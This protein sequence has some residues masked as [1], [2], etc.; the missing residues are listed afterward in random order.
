MK[1]EKS[2]C[3]CRATPGPPGI[4]HSHSSRMLLDLIEEYYYVLVY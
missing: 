3:R 1:I 4:L 2:L